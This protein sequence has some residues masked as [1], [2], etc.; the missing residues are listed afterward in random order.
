MRIIITSPSLDVS[1][2]VSGISSITQFIINNNT[3]HKYVHF[4]LGKKDAE[5]RNVAWFFR[6]LSIYVNWCYLLINERHG[7]IHFNLALSKA[8]IVRD[9]PLIM[10]SRIFGFRLIFHLHGGE[11]LMHKEMP[12]W[13]KYLLK[14]IFTD[15]YCKIALS[16]LEKQTLETKL[17]IK[18]V[19]I[20]PS[21]IDVKEA[22]GFIRTY[23]KKEKLKLLF[24]GRISENKGIGFIYLA[25][26]LLK[27]KKI[28]FQFT[29]AGMGAAEMK[30]VPKF[31]N[32]LNDDF[33]FEGSVFG[34][35]K[36]KLLKES[37]VFL[38]PSFFEGLPIALMESMS[39]GM[40][41]IIT[42]VGSIKYLVTD[43]LN[44]IFV[45]RYSAED[46]TFAIERISND[47]EYTIFLSKNARE[48]IL[49]NYDP[50]EYMDHLNEI[51]MSASNLNSK[52]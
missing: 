17:N 16:E 35:K 43:G 37:D 24:L 41:P 50:K 48:H 14:L 38:L 36:V 22:S 21:A 30:Y 46:I 31:K 51:Y 42:N 1:K 47:L 49:N 33:V 18:N 15:K 19:C 32:L 39:F 11:Y 5:K 29:M 7:L 13:M 12:L 9:I 40:V 34:E 4:E 27:K 25:L 8:S 3:K 10:I 6:I 28:K 2:N 52:S 23:Q 45:N 20:L 44:G 26:E